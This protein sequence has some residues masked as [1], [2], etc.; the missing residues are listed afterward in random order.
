MKSILKLFLFILIFSVLFTGC[1]AAPKATEPSSEKPTGKPTEKPTSAPTSKPTEKPTVGY[2]PVYDDVECDFTDIDDLI[3][4]YGRARVARDGITCDFTASGIEFDAFVDGE[5]SITLEC[6]YETYFSVIVDGEMYPDRYKADTGIST[7][8][9]DTAPKGLHH[10]RFLK[11][12]EPQHSTATLRSIEFYGEFL[13]TP[14]AEKELLIEF[15]GDSITCGYGN[16]WTPSAAHPSGE[17]GTP[18]YEDGTRAYSFLT[19]QKLGADH[20]IISFSGIGIDKGWSSINMQEFY[21]K[22]SYMRSSTKAYE[23]EDRTPDIV[24]IN[25]GTNDAAKGSTEEQMIANVK[26]LIETVRENYGEDT[27]IIWAYNMMG[28]CRFSWTE[29]A[30]EALGGEMN[31]IYSIELNED[32]NGGNGHPSLAAHE[33]AA[34]TLANFIRSLGLAE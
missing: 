14:P 5:I 34:T 29:Q 13:S 22:D 32:H 6:S 10:V 28:E 25:L 26:T 31:G 16:L 4:T 12:T 21:T 19:A 8:T 24:V 20:S 2:Q 1:N 17:S 33:T 23:P 15:I 18:L 3:K 9:F 7:I 30:L 11:Q 27:P